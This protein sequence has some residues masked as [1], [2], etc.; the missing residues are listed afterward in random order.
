MKRNRILD[1]VSLSEERWERTRKGGERTLRIESGEGF[2]GPSLESREWMTHAL[3]LVQR[4]DQTRHPLTP[5]N[6]EILGSD[7]DPVIESSN[8]RRPT[9]P[10]SPS[11]T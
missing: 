2:L 6:H 7:Y 8:V 11:R 10:T 5:T 4:G 3:P 9:E 1:W